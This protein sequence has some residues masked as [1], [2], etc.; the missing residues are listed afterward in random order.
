MAT[1]GLEYA[2][3]GT[4]KFYRFCRI[5][6]NA[7]FSQSIK[8]LAALVVLVFFQWLGNLV[9]EYLWIDLPAPLVGMLLLL[10]LLTFCP[11]LLAF[12]DNISE[13]LIKNLSL[14]FIP[15][16]VGAFFLGAAIYSQFPS[17]LVSIVVSTLVTILFMA[18]LVRFLA[19]PSRDT[20]K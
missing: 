15:P 2:R 17:L 3:L 5:G 13:L 4:G 18:V 8:L 14:M 12:L 10:I 6:G 20:S 9:S 16:S 1:D 7:I 11:A 19:C